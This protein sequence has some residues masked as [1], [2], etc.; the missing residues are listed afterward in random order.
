MKHFSSNCNLSNPSSIY[1]G[2]KQFDLGKL[3]GKVIHYN[4]ESILQYLQIKGKL[5]FGKNFKI[6][7]EDHQVS[8]KLPS[9]FIHDRKFTLKFGI[10]L[11]K[12]LLLSGTVGCGKETMMTLLPHFVPHCR[13]ITSFRQ[14]IL[15]LGSTPSV[16]K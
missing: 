6:Y 7:N 2:A 16:T 8:L 13:I 9:Y 15:L 1:E 5:M 12:G 4:F 11:D 3:D 10:D 14:E